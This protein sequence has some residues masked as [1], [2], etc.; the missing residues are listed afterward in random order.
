MNRRSSLRLKMGWWKLKVRRLALGRAMW[1]YRARTKG[2][3]VRPGVTVITVNYNSLPQ[4]QVLLAAL[5]RH[6]SQPIDV[7]VVDNASTD[8]SREFLR[9]HPRARPILLPL[10]IGHGF[11]L[12]LAVLS[13]STSNVVVFDIDAFPISPNWLSAVVDPLEHGAAIAGAHIHRAFIH[14]CFLAMRRS[15]FIAHRLSFAP[16]GRCPSPEVPATGLFLDTGEALSHVLSLA[17]GTKALHKIPPTSARGPGLIGTVI[18]DVVYHNF[19]S[20]H[21]GGEM[22]KAAAEAWEAAIREYAGSYGPEATVG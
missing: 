18:G 3:P 21:G 5:D 11:A 17:Y 12:D 14:P 15:N 16:V 10:N 9:G 2:R 7:I 13:A 1:V 19:F 4:L 20:T 6:T 22:G 8:G